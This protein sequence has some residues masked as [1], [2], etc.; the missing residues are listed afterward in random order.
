MCFFAEEQSINIKYYTMSSSCGD[1]FGTL[2]TPLETILYITVNVVIIIAASILNMTIIILIKTRVVLHQPSFILLAA[3]ACSD[4]AMVCVPAILYLTIVVKGKSNDGKVEI[5]TCYITSSISVNNILLVCC[6]THDRFQCIKHSLGNRPHTTKR[7]VALKIFICIISSFIISS[8]FYIETQ[9]NSLF[10]TVELL[11]IIAPGCFI[12]ITMYYF[13]LSRIIRLNQFSGSQTG[14][15]FS[16]GYLSRRASSHRS[17]LN[18]S[19]LMLIIS[20]IFAHLP[21]WITAFVR[22]ISYRL[23]TSPNRGIMVAMVWSATASFLNSVMDPLIYTYRSDSIWREL[24]RVT[25]FLFV[26]IVKLVVL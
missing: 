21:I 17:N 16:N 4:L 23:E 26:H 18:K 6:I 12:F 3:L 9:Y 10:R 14:A 15:Q 25:L 5:L 1:F 20:Y 2:S 22:N 24:R 8:A 11:F 7:K 13:R 19:I